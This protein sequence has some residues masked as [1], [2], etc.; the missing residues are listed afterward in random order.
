MWDIR[1]QHGNENKPK[2]D[3]KPVF[4]GVLGRISRKVEIIIPLYGK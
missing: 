3:I 2:W 4:V 1:V